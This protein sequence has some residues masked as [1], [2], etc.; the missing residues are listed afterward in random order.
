MPNQSGV[1]HSGDLTAHVDDKTRKAIQQGEFVDFV[2]LLP[3]NSASSLLTHPSSLTQRLCTHPFSWPEKSQKTPI[4]TFDRWLSAFSM[5]GT[6][7]LGAYPH[8]AVDMFTYLNIVQS[9]HKKV[10]IC[11]AWLAYDLDFK[12]RAARDP[13][14]SWKAIHPQ[15]Y[16]DPKCR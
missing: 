12:R 1:P 3:E 15:L 9:A 8:W 4:D 6:V 7:I 10:L 16:L 5:Y 13:I 11:L 2:S 14:L